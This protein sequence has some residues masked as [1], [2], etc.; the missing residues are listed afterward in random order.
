MALCRQYQIPHSTLRGGDGTWTALDRDKALA[1]EQYLRGT[2]PQCG[3]RDSDWTDETG[4]YQEAYV[5]LS[6][7]CFGCEE[8]ATKQGE[9]PDGKAGAGMKVLL[10]PASVYAA[11]QALEELTTTGR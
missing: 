1:Y 11:Q 6:H 10:L 8:I 2:C 7:K 3:T 5:A 4:E 9:I